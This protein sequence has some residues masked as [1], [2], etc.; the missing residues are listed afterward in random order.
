M[1][2]LGALFPGRVSSSSLCLRAGRRL[3]EG[4]LSLKIIGGEAVTSTLPT[5]PDLSS[6]RPLRCLLCVVSGDS[7]L[8]LSDAAANG[9]E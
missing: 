3:R 2:W 5:T 9:G 7:E 4:R 8:S 1:S 6:E